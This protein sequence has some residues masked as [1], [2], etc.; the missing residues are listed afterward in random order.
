[1]P[2]QHPDE[3]IATKVRTPQSKRGKVRVASLLAAAA[4]VFAARGTETATMTEIAAEAR[5]S[6][7]SLYQFFPTKELLATALHTELLGQL[8]TMLDDIRA[9]AAGQSP[10]LLADQVF[11]QLSDFLVINPSFVALADR[12]LIDP[13]RKRAVRARLLD[14]IADMLQAATPAVATDRAQILAIIILQLMKGTVSTD[15]G[16]DPVTRAQ[17][18]IELRSMLRTHLQAG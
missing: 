5:A 8:G 18:M 16:L 13:D 6:I 10:A 14:Q 4:T 12:R 1:M 17:V 7:G 15:A 11:E 2:S 9:T 3:S